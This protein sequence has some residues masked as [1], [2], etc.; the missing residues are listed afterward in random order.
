MMEWRLMMLSMRS[1]DKHTA[2]QY[3][4]SFPACFPKGRSLYQI[5]AHGQR[6][7]ASQWPSTIRICMRVMAA[8]PTDSSVQLGTSTLYGQKLATCLRRTPQRNVF[9]LDCI[10]LVRDSAPQVARRGAEYLLE[11]GLSIALYNQRSHTPA[12]ISISHSKPLFSMPGT[13]APSKDLQL[14]GQPRP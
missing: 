6:K 13:T 9:S 11:D 8:A 2:L 10:A 5:T 4:T 14:G 3:E 7:R 1:D 12:T